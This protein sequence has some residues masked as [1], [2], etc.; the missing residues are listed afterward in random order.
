MNPRDIYNKFKQEGLIRKVEQFHDS[1]NYLDLLFTSPLNFNES[2]FENKVNVFCPY[3]LEYTSLMDSPNVA[4]W[5]SG[6]GTFLKLFKR[7]NPASKLFYVN[8]SVN[9]LM[10]AK[11]IM[12]EYECVFTERNTEIKFD[13]VFS[14]G[15]LNLF[16]DETI[17]NLIAEMMNS[18]NENGVLMLLIN[19]DPNNL[20]KDFNLIWIHSLIQETNMMCVWGKNTFSS[21]WIKKQNN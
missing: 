19:L 3:F 4:E 15:V 14:D 2:A 9:S 12:S 5:V 18:L 8:D 20:R 10:L 11:E 17:K 13:I 7:I 1:E 6:V 16:D 21:M